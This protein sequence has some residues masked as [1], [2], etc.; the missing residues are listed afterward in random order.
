L[1]KV[2]LSNRR[3][4]IF[5]C[6]IFLIV[7]LNFNHQVIVRKTVIVNNNLSVRANNILKLFRRN[8]I[9][10]KQD[11]VVEDVINVAPVIKP[12]SNNKILIMTITGYDLS[13]RSTQKSRGSEG[14]GL[15]ATG[16]NLKDQTRV[17]AR[18]I[19]TD[20]SIVPLGSKVKLTFLDPKYQN[21]SGIYTSRDTGNGVK[22]LH[23]DLFLGDMGN[24]SSKVALTFGRT[25]C[26][27]E[28]IKE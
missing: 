1:R 2:I 11:K 28:I 14:F 26:E 25:K 20:N 3:F 8:Y 6:I 4:C 27:L 15:T 16:Y 21:Y 12:K 9:V 5:G 23:I 7:S 24:Q 19:A 22:G 13:Y 17:S 10:I 18:T